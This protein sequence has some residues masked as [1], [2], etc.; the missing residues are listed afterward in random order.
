[1]NGAEVIA[2][3]PIQ[4]NF[5][6]QPKGQV[7]PATEVNESYMQPGKLFS[8]GVEVVVLYDKSFPESQSLQP[9]QWRH[10]RAID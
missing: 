8:Q 7:L 3:D 1:M 4:Q 6:K 10:G 2:S 9:L 5:L